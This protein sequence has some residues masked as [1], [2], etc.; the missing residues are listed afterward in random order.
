MVELKSRVRPLARENRQKG[1]GFVPSKFAKFLKLGK[2][3]QETNCIL[4][5]NGFWL[6][7]VYWLLNK[8][9]GVVS[10]FYLLCLNEIDF[11]EQAFESNFK[12]KSSISILFIKQFTFRQVDLDTYEMKGNSKHLHFHKTYFQF[13][14][15]VLKQYMLI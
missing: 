6:A 15:Y 14:L 10:L 2:T 9:K 11:H 1:L 5:S 3:E 13:L 12:K 8:K 7:S 4:N